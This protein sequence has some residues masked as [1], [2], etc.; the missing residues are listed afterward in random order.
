M[1]PAL[2]N[3]V[4]IIPDGSRRW[5]K[6]KGLP[7]RVGHEITFFETTP[8]L[9]RCLLTAGIHT[10]TLWAFS[11]ENWARSAQEVDWLMQIFVRFVDETRES[12][13]A[14]AVRVRHIGRRDRLPIELKRALFVAEESTVSGKRGDLNI[15]LDYG[16]QDELANACAKYRAHACTKPDSLS[17]YLFTAGQTYPN[18]DLVI[19]T[20]GEQRLSGFMPWQTAYSELYFTRVLYPDMSE[21]DIHSALDWFSTRQRR[22]GT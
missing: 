3:H 12:A 18:P 5:A 13:A 1:S 8:K 20:S 15:A 4:A 11:T 16:G 14:N 7:P 9:I 17:S 2:P 6:S 10:I 22:H 19:R 21:A